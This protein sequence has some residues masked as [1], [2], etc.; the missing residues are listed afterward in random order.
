MQKK[1]NQQK[2]MVNEEASQGNESQL[3][4]NINEAEQLCQ[5]ELMRLDDHTTNEQAS[6]VV[7]LSKKGKA[8]D[9]STQ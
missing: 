5:E 6:K 4:L 1:Q 9:E 8:Q 2:M 7:K 3:Q